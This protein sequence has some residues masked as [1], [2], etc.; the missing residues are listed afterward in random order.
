MVYFS[1]AKIN[2]GHKLLYE[3]RFVAMVNLSE[4]SEVILVPP[5]MRGIAMCNAAR[6]ENVVSTDCVSANLTSEQDK[7]W[8][9]VDG[10]IYLTVTLDKPTAGDEWIPRMEK[11]GNR[12]RDYAKSVLRSKDFTSSIAGTH[13]I[14][15]L[16]GSLF[17]D[18]DRITQRIRAKADEMKLVKPNADIACLIR[19]QFSDK[20]IEAMG[21]WWIVTM[22]EPIVSGDEF[23]DESSL[24]TA[25]RRDRN[26]WLDV[27]L[28]DP[29]HRWCC[30]YGFAFLAPQAP[31]QPV[32]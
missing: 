32:L 12:A 4:C 5:G 31:Q 11:N 16:K 28:G 30:E 25:N 26:R 10:I 21:L 6:V 19:E 14:V 23:D 7:R 2:P 20:E 18:G 8:R 17:E 9:E 24:L 29:D 3:E 27:F 22:H 15:V 13:E 1:L